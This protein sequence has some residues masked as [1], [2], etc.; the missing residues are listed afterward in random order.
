MKHYY[1]ENCI[2]NELV[3]YG[4]DYYANNVF[5]GTDDEFDKLIYKSLKKGAPILPLSI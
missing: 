3:G 4:N 2:E 5:N 1:Y